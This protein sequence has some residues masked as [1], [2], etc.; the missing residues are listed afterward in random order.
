MDFE[1]DDDKNTKNKAKH[2]IRFED[3]LSLFESVNLIIE[4]DI[5][6]STLEEDR[7]IARGFLNYLGRVVVVFIEVTDDV[8]RIISARKE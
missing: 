5:E 1:W 2:G 7:Y 4:F 3:V 8:I 6:N